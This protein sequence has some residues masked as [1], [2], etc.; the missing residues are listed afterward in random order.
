MAPSP[1]LKIRVFKD[2]VLDEVRD[3]QAMDFGDAFMRQFIQV[4]AFSCCAPALDRQSCRCWRSNCT[5][6]SARA[7]GARC[8]GSASAISTAH[9]GCRGRMASSAAN[10]LAT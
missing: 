3:F 7:E 5:N 1:C 8:R 4:S 9:C 2:G 10:L 6:R